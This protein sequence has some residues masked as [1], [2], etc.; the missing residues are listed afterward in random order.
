MESE[1]QDETYSEMPLH[2]VVNVPRAVLVELYMVSRALFF[3]MIKIE[4]LV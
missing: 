1:T 4:P 2:D 3:I